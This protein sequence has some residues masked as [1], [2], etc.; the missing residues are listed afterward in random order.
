MT[1]APSKPSAASPPQRVAERPRRQTQATYALRGPS[2]KAARIIAGEREWPRAA[3]GGASRITAAPLHPRVGSSP[4]EPHGER[5]K[6]RPARQV[7]RAGERLV[8]WSITPPRARMATGERVEA[9]G[10]EAEPL[11]GRVE[12]RGGGGAGAR[13]QCGDAARGA[14]DEAGERRGARR[15]EGGERGG[16]GGDA[17]LGRAAARRRWRHLKASRRARMWSWRASPPRRWRSSRRRRIVVDVPARVAGAGVR[18]RAGRGPLKSASR[19][20]RWR[21]TSSRSA[22][23]PH[24]RA[25]LRG[26]G[27]V[28]A[29][30]SA[31]RSATVWST[32]G[33]TVGR[34]PA[35]G[36]RR[37]RGRRAQSLKAAR[38]SLEPPPRPR[39]TTGACA[40]A[41]RPGGPSRSAW[42]RRPPHERRGEH[43]AR[44]PALVDGARD[45]VE[46][47]PRGAG[48]H[49]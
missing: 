16:V 29:R 48:H 5:M 7:A 30:R 31:T 3:R 17:G 19:W 39:I 32:R 44:G 27:G 37:W 34:P 35:R 47:R 28:E 38:S 13:R 33:S 1:L 49:P 8:A 9:T 6:R 36:T 20:R 10:G 14:F 11:A 15:V 26:H 41:G 21:I 2:S 12:E 40:R 23:G 18:P 4:V 25:E 42:A 45:V 22:L 24:G 46:G 43:D